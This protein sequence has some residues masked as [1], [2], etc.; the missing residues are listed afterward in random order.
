MKTYSII[1]LLAR[2][3]PKAKNTRAHGAG[4]DVSTGIDVKGRWH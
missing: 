2:H 3:L 4:I 1:E